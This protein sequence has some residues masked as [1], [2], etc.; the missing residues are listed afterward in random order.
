M[1][2]P[3]LSKDDL[4]ILL[5]HCSSIQPQGKNIVAVVLC[6]CFVASK[7]FLD[8]CLKLYEQSMKEKAEK[9]LLKKAEMPT[10]PAA[11]RARQRQEI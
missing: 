11:G 10:A 5:T 3:I 1:A 9:G 6:D 7:G 2:P 8:R 4:A